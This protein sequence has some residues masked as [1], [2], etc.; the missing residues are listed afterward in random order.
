MTQLEEWSGACGD[1][2][3]MAF[4]RRRPWLST[5]S[6]LWLQRLSQTAEMA[7]DSSHL[8]YNPVCNEPLQLLLAGDGVNFSS[9]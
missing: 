6:W 4:A 7:T 1:M 9:P 3:G 5:Y 8:A 2:E